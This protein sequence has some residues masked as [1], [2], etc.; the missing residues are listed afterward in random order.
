M[1]QRKI[2]ALPVK[3]K[4]PSDKTLYELIG[5]YS[6]I[7]AVFISLSFCFG[8][9]TCLGLKTHEYHKLTFSVLERPDTCP[10]CG[11]KFHYLFEFD[12]DDIRILLH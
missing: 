11:W 1:N 5:Y 9:L 3:K 8:F 2:L 4:K 10:Y 12:E 6:T 7:L